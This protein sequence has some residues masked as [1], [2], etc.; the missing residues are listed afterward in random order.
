[1]PVIAPLPYV[2]CHIVQTQRV[3][4]EKLD[5]QFLAA[6]HALFQVA[7][8]ISRPRVEIRRIIN[9]S[10][11]PVPEPHLLPPFPNRMLPF[12]FRRQEVAVR[13]P[14]L[15]YAAPVHTIKRREPFPFTEP[16][17]VLDRVV[18]AYMDHRPL[19][20]SPV[21]VLRFRTARIVAECVIFVERHAVFPI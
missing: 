6:M 18:P 13:T 12:R 14:V 10:V 9:R 16:V 21:F 8:P 3:R 7:L 4:G 5:R 1:M 17:A 19:S 20:S 2:S 15:G 11:F